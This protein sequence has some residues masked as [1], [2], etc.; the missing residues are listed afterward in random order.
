MDAKNDFISR[1]CAKDAKGKI[2]KAKEMYRY[3]TLFRHPCC[4]LI[5]A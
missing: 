5:Q 2:E 3:L 4:L 1:N